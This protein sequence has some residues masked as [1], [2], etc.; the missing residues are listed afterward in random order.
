MDDLPGLLMIQAGLILLNAFFAATEIAVISLS[1]AKLKKLQESGDRTAGRLLKMTEEPSGFLSTIQIGI[2]LA[3]FLG[4]AFAA[5]NFSDPLTEWIYIDLGIKLLSPAALNTVSVILIT[6]ILSYFT[7]IFGELVPKRIAMQKSYEVARFSCAIVSTIAFMAKPVITFLSFSTNLVL[8][9]LGMK[10]EAEEE[11]LTEDEIRLMIEL[12]KEKGAIDE[13]ETEWIQ[14]VFDF[15]DTSILSAMTREADIINLFE[16]SSEQEILGVIRESG[17]SRLPVYTADHEDVAGILYTR[18]Y[19]L[20]LA[21][22]QP[23][24]LSQLLHQAYFV[25]ESIHA[26]DL[27]RDM[28]TKKVHMAIVVDEYGNLS[29]LITMEDLLEKIVGSIYDEFDPIIDPE[30]EKVNENLWR[31]PGDTPIKEVEEQMNIILPE[32]EEYDT[33]GGMLLS[34]LRTFPR[35]GSTVDVEAHGLS[36][37]MEKISHRRIQS[38]LVKKLDSDSDSLD[39]PDNLQ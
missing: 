2:T 14:N 33:I 8:R 7:L 34:R 4:S 36:L 19:L 9:L 17:L 1:S 28:Q 18:E 32:Q 29:G 25:P 13:D 5:D 10:T 3:G 26:D 23:K 21:A 38:V 12:G 31:F 35:D 15:R 24:P 37:H 22:K 30:V 20:N 11:N 6:L 39:S 16:D 27:F